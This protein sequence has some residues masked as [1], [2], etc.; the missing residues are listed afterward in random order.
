LGVETN[1]GWSY[2]TRNVEV[3]FHTRPVGAAGVGF[4]GF[5]G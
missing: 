3:G 2:W 5:F 4:G 1:A